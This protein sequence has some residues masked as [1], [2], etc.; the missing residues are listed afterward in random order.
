MNSNDKVMSKKYFFDIIIS[1]ELIFGW[2]C[3]CNYIGISNKSAGW[4]TCFW[5]LFKKASFFFK[6]VL[7]KH[8]LIDFGSII[9]M[10]LSA[11]MKFFVIGQLFVYKTPFGL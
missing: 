3:P 6:I 8:S 7:G 2:F 9:S 1:L 5:C 4:P 10:S 11:A